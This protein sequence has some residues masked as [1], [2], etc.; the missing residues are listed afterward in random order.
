MILDFAR[1]PFRIGARILDRQE[2]VVFG[3]FA[4][5]REYAIHATVLQFDEARELFTLDVRATAYRYWRVGFSVRLIG[6]ELL[7]VGIGRYFDDEA[8]A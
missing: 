7:S 2:R 8:Y 4:W 3:A 1:R 6:L 5:W